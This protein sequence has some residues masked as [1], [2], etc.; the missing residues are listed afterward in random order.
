MANFYNLSAGG[1]QTGSRPTAPVDFACTQVDNTTMDLDWDE[2]DSDFTSYSI[3]R[4]ISASSGFAVVHT[5]FPTTPLAAVTLTDTG[6]TKNV[7]YYYKFRVF[8]RTKW[9]DY[10][11]DNEITTNV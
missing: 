10:Q 9:S 8:K 4:S 7:R 2:T 1:C 6:L 5:G 3:E 11:T